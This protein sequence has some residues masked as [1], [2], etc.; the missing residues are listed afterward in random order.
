MNMLR[1]WYPAGHA[2]EY[3]YQLVGKKFSQLKSK[4]TFYSAGTGQ[5]KVD[6]MTVWLDESRKWVHICTI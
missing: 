6:E 2:S 4:K 5:T 3:T 1:S